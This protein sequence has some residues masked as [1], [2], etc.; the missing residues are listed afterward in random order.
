LAPVRAETKSRPRLIRSSWS[1]FVRLNRTESPAKGAVFHVQVRP[2][3]EHAFSSIA[4]PALNSSPNWLLKL[5]SQNTI[6]HRCYQEGR[7]PRTRQRN[8]PH[9]R[10]GLFLLY[11]AFFFPALTFAHRARCAAAIFLR[12]DADMV[13]LAGAEPVTAFAG[14]DPF[15]AFAH[16]ARCA[17]AIFLRE[18]ADTIRVGR[19]ALVYELLPSNLPRTER[20]A[21]TCRS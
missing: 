17:S 9:T 2:F 15:R 14:C 1:P 21:S 6:S 5:H 10:S 11:A 8:P 16:R 19:F 3:F 7:L 18:A 13:R 20:A 4:I 12:A